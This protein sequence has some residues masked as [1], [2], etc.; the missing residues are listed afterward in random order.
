LL[1]A[2]ASFASGGVVE[3]PL[4]IVITGD[5]VTHGE[6]YELSSREFQDFVEVFGF[7][8]FGHLR[9]PVYEGARLRRLLM[10]WP[11]GQLNID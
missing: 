10:M 7:N 6:D 11:A 2:R 1:V 4:G 8:D 3:E 9:W 5:L